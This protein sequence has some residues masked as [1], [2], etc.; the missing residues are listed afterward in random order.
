MVR[1]FV[2]FGTPDT[3]KAFFQSLRYWVFAYPLGAN[4][5]IVSV[6]VPALLVSSVMIFMLLLS[7]DRSPFGGAVR[8]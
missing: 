8:K 6:Y 2:V 1:Q 7:P 3:A 5:V 4:R